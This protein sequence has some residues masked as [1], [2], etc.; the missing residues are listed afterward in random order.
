MKKPVILLGHGVR[1]AGADPARLLTLGVPI[2]SSW[3]ASDVVD[4]RHENYFGRPGVYGWR[5]ANKVLYEA[6][7]IVA[8]GC[9]MSAWMIGHAG[10]RSEQ[11]LVM[12]DCDWEE[13]D[14]M[15][16]VWINEDICSF[17]N[18]FTIPSFSEWLTQ[19]KEW[20]ERYP[21]IEAIHADSN[22]YMNAYRIASYLNT[23]I[24]P[25]EHIVVDT[26]SLMCPVFQ[27]M[28]FTPP[29]RVYTAGGLGEMGNAMPGAIGISF[30]R[31]KKDVLCLMGDGGAMMNIQE[32]A[33]I[34]QHNI[35]VKMAVFEN[36]GYSMIKGTFNTVKRERV[37]VSRASG[38]GLPEIHKIA[39]ACGITSFDIT[40]WKQLQTV[41][42]W[43]LKAPSPILLN[44][45]IDPEQEFMPRLKPVNK[46][47]VITPP[48]FCDMSPLL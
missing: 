13:A 22:G 23:I 34:K 26:G 46:D 24:R 29:Q 8:I 12:V 6:D 25:D 48:R 33:T 19:C 45:R 3:M 38:L 9:R 17:I 40:D 30:A 31:G 14:R 35:P 1:L 15:K 28:R 44:I 18:S 42:P 7:Y 2:L 10:L 21:I 11:E 47:G 5:V 36:D 32:L 37:G 16:A 39:H 41:M 20:A 4:N 27:S 43:W